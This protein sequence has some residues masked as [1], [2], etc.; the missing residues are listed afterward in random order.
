MSTPTT[1]LTDAQAELIREIVLDV[2]ELEP[3]EL[4][5]SSHF[6][7]DHGADS[8]LAIEILARIE[9]DLGVA[10]PQD[11]LVELTSLENVYVIVARHQVG[12]GDA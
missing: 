5:L 11:D 3:E 6:V 8:L 10:I 1:T 4:T 12:G 7:D 9:R 2:L